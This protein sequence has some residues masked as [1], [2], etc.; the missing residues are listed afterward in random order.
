MLYLLTYGNA[1]ID[2]GSV[3]GKTA[4][5]LAVEVCDTGQMYTWNLM[6][7]NIYTTSNKCSAH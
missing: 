4:L 1:D 3:D 2:A 5:M 6:S 7:Y